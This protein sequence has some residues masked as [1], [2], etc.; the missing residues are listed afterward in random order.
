MFIVIIFIIAVLDIDDTLSFDWQ[1]SWYMFWTFWSSLI[2]APQVAEYEEKRY[3]SV[4][5]C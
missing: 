4:S 1:F 3:S 5:G 2:F